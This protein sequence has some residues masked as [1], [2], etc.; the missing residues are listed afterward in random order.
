MDKLPQEKIALLK[1]PYDHDY[2]YFIKDVNGNCGIFRAM[3]RAK[4]I[5]LE[6]ENKLNRER[7]SLGM[8]E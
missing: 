1:I 5:K 7:K 8:E 2:L 3:K 4:K 6:K